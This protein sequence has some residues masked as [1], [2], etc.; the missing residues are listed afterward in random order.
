MPVEGF[1]RPQRA[2]VYN[3]VQLKPAALAVLFVLLGCLL[4]PTLGVH[5]D[6]ALFAEVVWTPEYAEPCVLGE[7]RFAC[8]LMS[9]V[10]ADKAYLYRAIFSIFEPNVWSLRLP[11]LLTGAA[12]VALFF[13]LLRRA[14]P[15]RA[16]VLGAALLATDPAFLITT[17]FDWGPLA[18]QHLYVVAGVGLTLWG[19]LAARRDSLA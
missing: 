15:E 10:G 7:Q 3:R 13:A 9:Y 17:T 11:V 4:V 8:M 5:H 12:T 16:A 1:P 18:L 2:A 19:S 6:E 14:V